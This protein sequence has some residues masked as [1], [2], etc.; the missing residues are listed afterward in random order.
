[1]ADTYWDTKGVTNIAAL[2]NGR[3]ALKFAGEDGNN[4]VLTIP[5][6]HAINLITSLRSLASQVAKTHDVGETISDTQRL[7]ADSIGVGS[8]PDGSEFSLMVRTSDKLELHLGLPPRTAEALAAG[9]ISTLAEH[10]REPENL[11]SDSPKH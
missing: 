1:M 10:G 7:T 11:K 3:L 6:S 8:A 2:K 9:L 4:R 5:A